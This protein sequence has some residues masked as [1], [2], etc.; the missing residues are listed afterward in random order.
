MFKQIITL[1]I[2]LIMNSF[3]LPE[4]A[5]TTMTATIMETSIVGAETSAPI[6]TKA[7]VP[8]VETPSVVSPTPSPIPTKAPDSIVETPPTAEDVNKN[9]NPSNENNTEN[10]VHTPDMHSYEWE[11]NGSTR[12]LKCQH[13]DHQKVTEY[14]YNGVWGYYDDASANTLWSYVNTTRGNTQYG[15]MEQGVCIGIATVDAL[16]TDASLTE[17]ARLRATETATNF[18]H[19][20]NADEC[21]AW[22]TGSPEITMDSWLLSYSHCYA[23]TDPAYIHG[24]IACFWFDSNN[25]GENLTPIWVLELGR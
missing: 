21:L 12:T 6:P 25:S 1:I 18:S 19:G 23:I 11:T 4:I 14:Y 3:T 7:P 15:V 20:E 17:K 2:T 24:G 10:V 16:I 22:G 13:C 9:S 8:V 5:K